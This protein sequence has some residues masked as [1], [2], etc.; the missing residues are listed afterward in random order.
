MP[1]QS[2]WCRPV[3]GI[4][5]LLAAVFFGASSLGLNQSGKEAAKTAA[6]P[7]IAQ[8]GESASSPARAVQ[9]PLSAHERTQAE[10][11]LD[12]HNTALNA[13]DSGYYALP[14]AL[15]ANARFY[16][17]TWRLP[18]KP[19]SQ[20]S[21]KESRKRLAAGAGLFSEAEAAKLALALDDMD[22][23]LDAA[24]DHYKALED[25]VADGN[26]RDD[27]AR[28]KALAGKLAKDHATFMAARSSWLEIVE[29]RARACEA[30]L[31]REHPLQRQISAADAIFACFAQV[32]EALGAEDQAKAALDA[33][34]LPNP[35][36]RAL[37]ERIHAEL[38]SEIAQAAK[39]PFAAA[40]D[41]ER[42]YRAF[43]KEATAYAAALERGL[44]EGF[45]SL[46]RRELNLAAARSRAAYNAFARAANGLKMR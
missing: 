36:E 33:S 29:A 27:G 2:S 5:I 26:I 6:T 19:V 8:A 7:A 43:L 37:L 30:A 13:L 4:L 1:K 23:A 25:Y 31:L 41:L 32:A 3:F 14:D 39:P 21:R 45:F 38:E 20:A 35:S 12:F 11:V 17:K 22:K 40:P 44:G 24:L 42:R 15:Y 10:R 34:N 9:A 16:L 18:P 46:Q 28:G